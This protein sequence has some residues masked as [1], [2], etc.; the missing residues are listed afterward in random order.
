MISNFILF[1]FSLELWQMW[2]SFSTQKTKSFVEAAL[3]LFW[4]T[5]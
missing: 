1:Y 2:A 5:K 3:A 4:V